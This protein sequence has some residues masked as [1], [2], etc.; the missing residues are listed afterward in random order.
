MTFSCEGMLI[1]TLKFEFG[2]SVSHFRFFIR[3]NDR[4]S[5]AVV[6]FK[7]L[8]A[9]IP[10]GIDKVKRKDPFREWRLNLRKWKVYFKTYA[11]AKPE[12]QSKLTLSLEKQ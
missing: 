7:D 5:K 8:K 9:I 11:V 3:T 6:Q 2:E 12:E 10:R 4:S 1:L